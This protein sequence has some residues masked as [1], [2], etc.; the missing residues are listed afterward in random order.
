MH[1]Y[2]SSSPSPVSAVSSS[3]SPS[4]FGL[5]PRPRVPLFISDI[6]SIWSTRHPVKHRRYLFALLRH[7]YTLVHKLSNCDWFTVNGNLCTR[8]AILIFSSSRW[9][10]SWFVWVYLSSQLH[11][12]LKSSCFLVSCCLFLLLPT[13]YKVLQC[14]HASLHLTFY[15]HFQGIQEEQQLQPSDSNTTL[16][17]E[18]ES[19]S[20]WFDF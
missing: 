1:I 6:L 19:I 13:F 17:S 14:T 8:C 2:F 16:T 12:L 3:L 9:S 10:C 15:F 18:R 5:C 20:D 11:H 4:L 7:L